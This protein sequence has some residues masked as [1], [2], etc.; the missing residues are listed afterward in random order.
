MTETVESRVRQILEAEH[1]VDEIGV[2]ETI[3]QAGLDSLDRVELWM[4]LEEVF[5]LPE[6]DPEVEDECE[7][8]GQIVNYVERK[9]RR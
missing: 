6:T 4:E 1:G 2:S 9:I 3:E 7:T 5:G 8:V